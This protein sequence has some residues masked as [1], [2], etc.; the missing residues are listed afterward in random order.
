MT[1]QHHVI[2][3]HAASPVAPMALVRGIWRNRQLLVHMTRRDVVGR[4]QGSVMGLSWALLNPL[5]MLAV[6]TAV[7][8]GIF[9]ARWNDAGADGGTTQFA[10]MLFVGLIVFNFF[11][12][13][14]NRAPTLILGNVNYV[15]KVVFPLELLPI[16]A[17]VTAL[18]HALVSLLVLML[19]QALLGALPSSWTMLLAPVVL[20]PFIVLTCGLAWLLAALGV[21]L[22]DIGQSM[23][24]V[25]TLLMFLSPVFYPVSAVPAAMREWLVFNPLTFVIEQTRRVLLLGQVPDWEGLAVY[26]MAALLVTWL[27]Y[28]WF[29]KTRKGFADVI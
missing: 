6:Y 11:A 8:S 12:E 19:A 23:G 18:F 26:T 5:L 7:F 20:A 29:Q 2:D 14:L 3:P 15:K 25:T 10:L 13:L 28:A 27:G 16:M 9:K 21:Y 22:R 1:L 4:Y 17:T 24:L